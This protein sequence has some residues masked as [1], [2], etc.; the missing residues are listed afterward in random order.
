MRLRKIAA[1]NQ[2]YYGDNLPIMRERLPDA[3]AD[4]VYLDPPFNSNATYNLPF[5]SEKGGAA[6]A[7]IRAFTDAWHWDESAES[8]YAG[9]MAKG[10]ETAIAAKA[11]REILGESPMMAYLAMMGI[12]L[13]ELRRMLKDTGSIYLHCDPTTSHYIKIL[14]DRIFGAKNFRNEIIWHYEIGG[15]PRRD[16]ARKHDVILRYSKTDAYRFY[17]EDVREPRS[18]EVLRRIATGNKNATRATGQTR[19]PTDIFKIPAI[20]AMAKE[21]I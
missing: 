11:L 20:N 15:I 13:I 4:L 6:A 14:M 7:Q 19:H 2:L 17:L 10:G 8:A 9:V 18:D 12:R 3:C 1:M 16:F 5:K 21:R